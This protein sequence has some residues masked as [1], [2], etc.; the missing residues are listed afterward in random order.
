MYVE[1]CVGQMSKFDL[2][3]CAVQRHFL[4]RREMEKMQQSLILI[5][6]FSVGK[7]CQRTG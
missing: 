7:V 6:H 5:R 3:C 1:E 4:R 2:R